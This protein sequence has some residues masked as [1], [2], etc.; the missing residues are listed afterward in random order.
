MRIPT[1]LTRNV[2]RQMFLVQKHSP[3]ILFGAGI[4]GVVA[5]AVMA[6]KATLQ[7]SDT[8]QGY[9]DMKDMAAELLDTNNTEY[10]EDD[11]RKDMRYVHVRAA[12]GVTKLY[13]PAVGLGIVS[14]ACLTQSHVILSQRNV[15]L[16]AAYA[17]LDKGFTEYR[18]RVQSEVGEDREREL[19]YG[20]IT[21]TTTVDGKQVKRI[22]P[23][24]ESASIYARFFDQLSSSWQREPEYN[25]VFLKCQQNY[26]N[27]MLR[28][29]GHLFLNE[30]YDML[31][32]PRSKAGA[33]VGWRISDDGDCF[34]DFGL[35]DGNEAARAFVNGVEGAILLDF[36]VDGVIYDKL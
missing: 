4:V 6:S 36:N 9:E 28:A 17:A 2:S 30:V 20:G 19:R 8:L 12:I 14:V 13:A 18:E 35:Y 7:L 34:V 22:V 15:A 1:A 33:V 26:A 23:T 31:G 5:T 16:S 25:L 3:H 32:I 10:T 27:D 21:K 24:P 29:R 11:Y